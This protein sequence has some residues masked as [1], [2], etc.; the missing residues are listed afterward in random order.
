LRLEGGSGVI[1]TLE[2]A[3]GNVGGSLPGEGSDDGGGFQ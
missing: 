1:G 3:P 2:V